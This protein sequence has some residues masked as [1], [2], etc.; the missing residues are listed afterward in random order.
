MFTG[1]L[2]AFACCPSALKRRGY[3]PLP[4][5]RDRQ[6]AG[7][8]TDQIFPRKPLVAIATATKVTAVIATGTS[9]R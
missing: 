5:A 8:L 4:L 7:Y 2:G 6:I 3:L 1:T 9:W